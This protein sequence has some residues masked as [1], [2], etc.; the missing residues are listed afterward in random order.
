MYLNLSLAPCFLSN[1]YL[2]L[3]LQHVL[4]KKTLVYCDLSSICL[5]SVFS[6]LWWRISWILDF[7]VWSSV[8]KSFSYFISAHSSNQKL[9]SLL[10]SDKYLP[11][12]SIGF[13]LLLILSPGLKKIWKKINIFGMHELTWKWQFLLP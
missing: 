6:G 7:N 2:T 9:V 5:G 13:S 3:L 1:L 4:D 8:C 10:P 11:Q 12:I